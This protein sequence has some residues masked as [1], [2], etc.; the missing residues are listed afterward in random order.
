MME[1]IY[2]GTMIFLLVSCGIFFL[3]MTY[4]GLFGGGI[5]Y[6]YTLKWGCQ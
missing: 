6:S 5:D 4:E 1:K 3:A 2:F